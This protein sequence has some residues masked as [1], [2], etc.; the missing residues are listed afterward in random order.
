MVWIQSTQVSQS[1]GTGGA[2]LRRWLRRSATIFAWGL[3]FVAWMFTFNALPRPRN[4]HGLALFSLLGLAVTAV[5]ASGLAT[6]SAAYFIHRFLLRRRSGQGDGDEASLETESPGFAAV[7]ARHL[8]YALQAGGVLSAGAGL[9]LTI[10]FLF[11]DASTDILPA[12]LA[13]FAISIVAH[14][15]AWWL[16]THRRAGLIAAAILVLAPIGALIRAGVTA[17]L[18]YGAPLGTLVFIAS[19]WRPFRYTIARDAP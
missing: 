11:S 4:P 3:G 13:A 19:L 1:L 8:A 9:V 5:G 6:G 15:N 17:P 18:A 2:P 16:H 7:R 14:I 12:M 10:G